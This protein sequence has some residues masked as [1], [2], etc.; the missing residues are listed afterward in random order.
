MPAFEYVKMGKRGKGKKVE[1]SL[2]EC[3]LGKGT[4][5][6]T[7][8]VCP[9]KAIGNNFEVVYNSTEISLLL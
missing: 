6:E 3:H 1:C 8:S 5:I 9:R 4:I 7:R 2:S